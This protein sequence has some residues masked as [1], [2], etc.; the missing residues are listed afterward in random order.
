ME[1]LSLR[2][3][4]IV[5][6]ARVAEAAELGQTLARWMLN[7]CQRVHVVVAEQNS[8]LYQDPELDLVIILGGDGT[9]LG[10]ARRV[11]DRKIPLVSIN[12]GRVGFLSD[13]EPDNWEEQLSKILQEGNVYRSLAGLRWK[14]YRFGHLIHSGTAVNDLVIGRSGMA[15]LVYVDISVNGER[16]GD[17]RADGFL[18]GTP[19]GS[20]GYSISAGGPLLQTS[21]N[22]VNFVPI[23]PFLNIIPPMVFDCHTFFR[24]HMLPG[25]TDSY[26]T[27]DGQEGHIIQTNDVIEVECCPDCVRFLGRGISLVERIRTRSFILQN[28]M[29]KAAAETKT[30]DP[31]AD[32][33][34]EE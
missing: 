24:F 12:F 8:P 15:R 2:T 27:L 31:D 33:S 7:H 9:I 19:M 29:D 14:L 26:L 3:V 5:T 21:L 17:V 10:V 1:S 16:M 18:L 23:C 4:L 34:E 13:I 28:P 11:F 30:Q 20:S 6:K 25:T 22:V 32:S